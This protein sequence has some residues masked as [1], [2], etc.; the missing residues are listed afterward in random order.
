MQTPFEEETTRD[1]FTNLYQG[2]LE[3][4]NHQIH[5]TQTLLGGE[6]DRHQQEAIIGFL[7]L[8]D[9]DE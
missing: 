5:E 1:H 6:P 2:G 3:E 9:S 8:F 4:L 7:D